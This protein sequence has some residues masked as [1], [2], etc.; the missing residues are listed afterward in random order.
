MTEDKLHDDD[1]C[2]CVVCEMIRSGFCSHVFL[3]GDLLP[4]SFEV[5]T[6]MGLTEGQEVDEETALRISDEL[7]RELIRS[8]LEDMAERRKHHPGNNTL[9]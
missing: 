8:I 9:N 3:D 1:E 6:K 5:M 7:A 4:V 2:D